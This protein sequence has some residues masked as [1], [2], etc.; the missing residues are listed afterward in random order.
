[1]ERKYCIHCKAEIDISQ[2]NKNPTR[3]DGRDNLCR[4]HR[5]EYQQK[6]YEKNREKH[7]KRVHINNIAVRERNTELLLDYLLKHPCLDC[8]ESDPLV[9]E[10]DHV[11]GV[12]TKEI[13]C[14]I[15]EK[16]SWKAVE[17]EIDKCVVRCANCHRRKT[18]YEQNWKV[19]SLIERLGMGR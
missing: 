17:A 13:S 7:I 3:R 6:W 8:G 10:F 11:R 5:R 1:M 4:I 16:W 15:Q 9:L 2:F 19:V 14:M 18:A 12:K